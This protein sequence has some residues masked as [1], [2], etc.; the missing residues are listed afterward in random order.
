DG[1]VL[2]QQSSFVTQFAQVALNA[3]T[4]NQTDVWI[5]PQFNWSTQANANSYRIQIDKVGNW[6]QPLIDRGGLESGSWVCETL[7]DYGEH[8]SWRM[9][10]ETQ[11]TALN[12][13]L[14]RE[15]ITMFYPTQF[16]LDREI[17]FST[18]SSPDQYKSSD[19]RLIGIPG[20]SAIPIDDILGSGFG[21][22]WMAYWD[23]G[24]AQDYL[25]KYN[26]GSADFHFNAGR[27]FWIIYN[28]PFSINKNIASAPL[29][30]EKAVEIPV[31]TGWN[32]LTNPFDKNIIWQTVLDFNGIS[33]PIHTFNGSYSTA[34]I[35]EPYKGY[36]YFNQSGANFIKFP[37]TAQ[38]MITKPVPVEPALSWKMAI[39]LQCAEEMDRGTQLGVAEKARAGIDQFD[40]RKPRGIGPMPAVIFERPEWDKQ[41]PGFASDVRPPIDGVE[42]WSFKTQTPGGGASVMTFPGLESVPEGHEIYLVDKTRYTF[43]NLREENQYHYR[44]VPEISEFDLVIGD[45][46][47]VQEKLDQIVPTEFALGK[48]F[49]NPFNPVTTISV[50]LPE[51]SEVTLKIYNMLGQEMITL[52]QGNLQAGKHFFTWNAA[53]TSG[54]TLPSG[55]YIYAMTTAKGQR[56]AD[57]MVLIK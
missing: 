48:N 54:N 6:D 7:L 32:L 55:V 27:A 42:T 51:A 4:A 41:Y 2:G 37:A 15:F 33:G 49:P 23:N 5:Q 34:S 11:N 13:S 52:Y 24:S 18:K 19:Y 10:V 16:S 45:A 47:E 12:W 17:V 44:G 25:K 43:T 26:E 3:P 53:N 36:Y 38:Q 40:Y 21:E 56:F 14:A 22:K 20:A 57:K 29:S 30:A 1:E 50:L 35:M 39:N 31:H 46:A 28:G 9:A 8:Y